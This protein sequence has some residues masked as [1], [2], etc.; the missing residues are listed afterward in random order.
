MLPT[1][2]QA[3]KGAGRLY[4][5]VGA[6]VGSGHGFMMLAPDLWRADV[7]AFLAKHLR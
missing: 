1:A 6:D 4:P 3:G 7:L 2:V 5:A